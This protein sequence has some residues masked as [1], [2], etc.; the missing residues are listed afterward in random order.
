MLVRWAPNME[1]S[2][3]SILPLQATRITARWTL[4]RETAVEILIELFKVTV[5][6][7]SPA[8]VFKLIHS[9]MDSLTISADGHHCSYSVIIALSTFRV[10]WNTVELTLVHTAIMFLIREKNIWCFPRYYV[11]LGVFFVLCVCKKICTH[12][13]FVRPT[14]MLIT[15]QKFKCGNV[16]NWR[17]F[18]HFLFLPM[19]M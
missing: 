7:N 6:A 2:C 3:D 4:K 12:K 8:F 18:C 16:N 1:W 13:L 17:N 10:V 11:D 15:I 5:Q 14:S 9:S 19:F